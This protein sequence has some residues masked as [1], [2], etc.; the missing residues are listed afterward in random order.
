MVGNLGTDWP[1]LDIEEPR[2]LSADICTSHPS[3]PVGVSSANRPTPFSSVLNWSLGKRKTTA[4]YIPNQMQA[5][6]IA[7]L[8]EGRVVAR[9][10]LSYSRRS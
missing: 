10:L 3:L 9:E 7:L 5:R 6:H 1:I 8:G 4:K 2:H